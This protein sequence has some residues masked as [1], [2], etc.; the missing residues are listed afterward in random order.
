MQDI[1]N[2]V[3]STTWSGDI[4]QGARR[5]SFDIAYNVTSKDSSFTALNIE[6]GGFIFA[7]YTESDTDTPIE[8]FCGRI[9]YRKRNTDQ[10]TYSFTVYDD[11]IYLVKSKV[12][13]LFSNVSVTDAIKQTCNEIGIPV[14]DTILQIPTVVNF[15]ADG[16]S[17]TEVFRMLRDKSKADTSNYPAGIDFTV[18]CLLDKVAI[19][20][21]GEEI[22]KYVASD[23]INVEHTEHSQSVESMI[24]RIKAVDSVGRICQVFTNTDDTTHYGMIQDIY[25]MQPPKK[26]ETVDNVKAAKEKLKRVNEESSLD[27][28][29]NIQCITGYTITVQEQQLKG[30]F[31]IKSDTHKFENNI[32]TMQLTLEY[33][34]D[35]P[36][37]PTI[38]QQ[39]IA[40]PIFKSTGKGQKVRYDGNG[41]LNVQ[42]GLAAG[43]DAWGNTTMDNGANGCAEAVGKVGGYYSSFLAQEANNGVVGVEGMVSDADSAGLLQDFDAGSLE[44]GDTIVY[45]DNDHVVIYDGNGGYYG[46][47]TSRKVTVHGRDYTNMSG[48]SPTKIIKSSRG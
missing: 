44:A 39:D 19:I 30:K 37:T 42:Q 29:G 20:K 41:N 46:N 6:L 43:W 24:N 5:I 36:E 11:M 40:T 25:K 32:H 47:S 22:E 8:I 15:I 21:K 18:I 45:G 26:N 1:T 33:L 34:P 16:K 10:F 48:M 2:Y 35:T 14:A 23:S 13:L 3:L 17:C 7:F 27:G 9:F 4:G 12:Q 28:I 31:F 38:E